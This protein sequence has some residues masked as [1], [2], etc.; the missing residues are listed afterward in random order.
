MKSGCTQKARTGILAFQRYCA[1]IS[2]VV[3]D[4]IRRE[5]FLVG[6]SAVFVCYSAKRRYTP[7]RCCSLLERRTCWR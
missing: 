1:G 5:L 6:T 4:T 7:E 2:F 3:F